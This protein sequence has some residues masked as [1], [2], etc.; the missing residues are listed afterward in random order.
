MNGTVRL[1]DSVSQA[2]ADLVA[3]GVRRAGTKGFSLVLSGGG[4]A[5]ECYQTLAARHGVDW[6]ASTCSWGTSGA[7]RLTTRTP[8]T[9]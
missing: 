3:D 8:T 1:V 2:F 9:A 5:A 4:T 7:C 6:S